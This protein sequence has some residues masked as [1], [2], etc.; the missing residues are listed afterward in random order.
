VKDIAN[1]YS[2]SVVAFVSRMKRK[3]FVATPF[4][5][6]SYSR[7]TADRFDF[8]TVRGT[9]T[10]FITRIDGIRARLGVKGR[11]PRLCVI[12]RGNVVWPF[13]RLCG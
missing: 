11:H 1:F 5:I 6:E 12:T 2:Y 7:G 13:G 4:E 8:G 9:K 10:I 3:I